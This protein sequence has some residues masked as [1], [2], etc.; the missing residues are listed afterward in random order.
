MT[1]RVAFNATPLLSPLTGIGNYIVELGAALAA[2]GEVDAYSFYRYRWRHEPPCPP[3]EQFPL[4]AAVVQRIKPWLPF[5]GTLRVVAQQMGFS[6]GLREHRIDLYHEPNYVPLRYDVPVVITIHDLSWL[7]Y[8][9]THPVDRVRWLMRGMPRAI[10]RAR[11]IIVDSHFVRAEVIKEFGVAP[12]RV[13]TA[14]LGVSKIYRQRSAEETVSTLQPLGLRHGNYLL[15]VGTIEPRKNVGHVLEAFAQIPAAIRE[16]FPLVI[17]GA[18]GWRA[19]E[20]VGRLRRLADLGQIR[21]LGH[22]G[23]D[24][25]PHLYAG[26]ASFVFPSLYEGFGLPPL[27][28]MASGVPVLASNRASLPEVMGDAGRMLEPDDVNDTAER[29]RAML[30]DPVARAAMAQRGI[31]RA[32]EFTW[33]ACAAATR[34]VYTTAV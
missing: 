33:G 9:E 3:P 27:E 28:A 14:H 22:V 15:T 34:R 31:A 2:T 18:R 19:T 8:P 1:L 11:A 21:F 7:H 17:A 32:A 4:T 20:I 12:E 10:D 16:R 25:L 6:R 29:I 5:R 30:D 26:A 23:D 13:H 24:A